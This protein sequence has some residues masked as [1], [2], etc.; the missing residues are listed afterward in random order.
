MKGLEAYTC[1]C[2]LDSFGDR[3]NDLSCK[4]GA[5]ICPSVIAFLYGLELLNAMLQRLRD[6]LIWKVLMW[7]CAFWYIQSDLVKKPFKL[8]IDK[9]LFHMF[10]FHVSILMY[11]YSSF[12]WILADIISLNEDSKFDRP[13]IEM[14]DKVNSWERRIQLSR[15]KDSIIAHWRGWN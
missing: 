10:F 12:S 11:Q 5:S 4:L 6:R 14:L 9:C 7:R 15:R 3:K 1:I 13:Y 8:V 2:A